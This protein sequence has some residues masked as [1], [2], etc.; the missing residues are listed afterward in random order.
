MKVTVQVVIEAENG[1]STIVQEVDRWSGRGCS[2]R[3]W[4]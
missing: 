3:T 1:T 2:P 4:D